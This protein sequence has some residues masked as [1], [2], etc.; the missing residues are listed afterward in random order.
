[1]NILERV[2]VSVRR[3]APVPAEHAI[4]RAIRPVYRDLLARVGQRGLERRINGTDTIRVLAELYNLGE[5]YEPE[6]W[7]LVMGELRNDD[8]VADVGAS[9]GLYT[10]AIARRLGS[11]GRMVAFEADPSTARMLRTMV[12]LN[13]VGARTTVVSAAVGDRPGTIRFANGR[14]VE[15]HVTLDAQPGSIEVDMI[16]LDSVFPTESVDLVKIDVEGYEEH[17]LRGAE[18]LLTDPRRAPRTLF[19]E[20]HPFAWS[21]FGV[22]GE[23]LLR[24]LNEY[25]YDALDLAGRSVGRIDS[26]GEVIARKRS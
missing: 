3:S 10:L 16:T 6:V 1:M 5:T 20:V 9:I 23:S 19:V 24:I 14:G 25:G 26:Y 11:A 18:R 4:W 22:S 12:E 13:G 2:A 8:T 21:G 7:R 17:V 15:S